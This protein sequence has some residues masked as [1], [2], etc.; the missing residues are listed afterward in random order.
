[1]VF[2]GFLTPMQENKL[3][4]VAENISAPK[5]NVAA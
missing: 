1:M 2:R 4:Y 5:S 3:P